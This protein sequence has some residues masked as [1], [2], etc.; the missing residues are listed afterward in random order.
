M[1]KEKPKKIQLRKVKRH[2]KTPLVQI[3]KN[4]NVQVDIQTKSSNLI[5]DNNSMENIII[6]E[7]KVTQ[8]K[9]IN[10]NVLNDKTIEVLVDNLLFSV[11][12]K[13]HFFT[14]YLGSVSTDEYK[15][16][17]HIKS[18]CGKHIPVNSFPI[19]FDSGEYLL[20][21]K[22]DDIKNN[23]FA[24]IHDIYEKSFNGVHVGYYKLE[25]Y[26]YVRNDKSKSGHRIIGKY[27]I[28]KNCN[29]FYICFLDPHHLLA[30]S[31]KNKEK[32]SKINNYSIDI[33]DA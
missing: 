3:A 30:T 2:E 12:V 16:V 32:Y 11:N 21:S 20:N 27:I 22:T 31:D 23:R 29:Q 15:E 24:T 18:I 13:E 33:L 19:D 7:S 17:C 10:E 28:K 4:S 26:R 9:V 25:K 6:S 14:N 5:N 1:Q 8:S